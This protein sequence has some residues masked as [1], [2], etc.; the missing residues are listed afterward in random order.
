MPI[1]S[2]DQI[3]VFSGGQEPRIAVFNG[4]AILTA[5]ATD[6]AMAHIDGQTVPYG[7]KTPIVPPSIVTQATTD[8]A[9]AP[10]G[11][12]VHKSEWTGPADEFKGYACMIYPGYTPIWTYG[13]YFADIGLQVIE[14]RVTGYKNNATGEIVTTPVN[15]AVTASAGNPSG[16]F[17]FAIVPV[18]SFGVVRGNPSPLALAADGNQYATLDSQTAVITWNPSDVDP[19]ADK[20]AIICAEVQENVWHQV[21]LADRTAGTFTF[22]IDAE[23]LQAQADVFPDGY[24]TNS[25]FPPP[26]RAVTPWNNRLW[27]WCGG[28]DIMLDGTGKGKVQ[29]ANQEYWKAFPYTGKS[30]HG[31]ITLVPDGAYRFCGQEEGMLFYAINRNG[32]RISEAYTVDAVLSPTQLRLAQEWSAE[33]KAVELPLAKDSD[34]H[35]YNLT[36]R[37]AA[38]LPDGRYRF[39]LAGT[40]GADPYGIM[41]GEIIDIAGRSEPELQ[42][43][44]VIKADETFA[45]I[46]VD[47][48]GV[49]LNNNRLWAG[50]LKSVNNATTATLVEGGLGAGSVVGQKANFHGPNGL[51]AV[52]IITANTDNT[53]SW[54]GDLADW[55]LFTSVTIGTRPYTLYTT[56]LR[57]YPDHINVLGVTPAM[58]SGNT[59]TGARLF[60]KEK[61][62]AALC[63]RTIASA[64]YVGP[65]TTVAYAENNYR[66]AGLTW[67]TA[68]KTFDQFGISVKRLTATGIEYSAD[69][70]AW[71]A[72]DKEGWEGLQVV[73]RNPA[74][75][76]IRVETATGW[77]LAPEVCLTVP[78][79]ANVTLTEAQGYTECFIAGFVLSTGNVTDI[80]DWDNHPPCKVKVTVDGTVP[81]VINTGTRLLLYSSDTSI[82]NHYAT[83][84]YVSEHV[85]TINCD[86]TQKRT[87]YDKYAIIAAANFSGQCQEIPSTN[88]WVGPVCGANNSLTPKKAYFINRGGSRPDQATVRSITANT[89]ETITLDTAPPAVEDE[90][91]ALIDYASRAVLITEHTSSSATWNQGI[92][93]NNCLKGGSVWFLQTQEDSNNYLMAVPVKTTIIAS[94]QIDYTHKIYWD[95]DALQAAW[96]AF[97]QSKGRPLNQPMPEFD[98]IFYEWPE[99]EARAIV[100]VNNSQVALADT[101]TAL[102]ADGTLAGKTIRLFTSDGTPTNATIA[103]NTAKTV[104]LSAPVS[105]ASDQTRYSIDD[106]SLLIRLADDDAAWAGARIKRASGLGAPRKAIMSAPCELRSSQFDY[107]DT[108]DEAWPPLCSWTPPSMDG[109]HIE[110]AIQSGEVFAVF[111]KAAMILAVAQP[112]MGVPALSWHNYRGIGITGP[113]ALAKITDARGNLTPEDILFAARSG[114]M[115]FVAGNLENLTDNAGCRAL[116]QAFTD[117]SLGDAVGAYNPRLG[118]FTLSNLKLKGETDSEAGWRMHYNAT[119]NAFFLERYS[120]ATALAPIITDTGAMLFLEG[121]DRGHINLGHL[122]DHQSR[123]VSSEADRIA[124][125]TPATHWSG[126]ITWAPNWQG[127]ETMNFIPTGMLITNDQAARLVGAYVLLVHMTTGEIAATRIT[128]VTPPTSPGSTWLPTITVNRLAPVTSPEDI[129][130]RDHYTAGI[131]GAIHLQFVTG[132]LGADNECQKQL[133]GLDITLRGPAS[134][135]AMR[136]RIWPAGSLRDAGEVVSQT[137][138]C[139]MQLSKRVINQ[140]TI[141]LPGLVSQAYIAEFSGAVMDSNWRMTLLQLG[142]KILRGQYV[143]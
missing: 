107:N 91:I 52:K 106:R 90:R 55:Q 59:F 111:T 28:P 72:K 35:F 129:Q 133:T 109:Q 15:P 70:S 131:I 80:V 134:D 66:E 54:S 84:K 29:I 31:V 62:A 92:I 18:R 20:V 8:A 105:N 33:T 69:A 2:N 50:D 4:R 102:P 130:A 142:Y 58:L 48:P 30:Q 47:T 79:W 53:I 25:A 49:A 24:N 51:I 98:R 23:T 138:R 127:G 13:T 137:P 38:E 114:L 12:Y 43:M 112:G 37:E 136:L 67:Y 140:G 27:G 14:W 39:N 17:F 60:T 113:K 76:E 74:T 89:A 139:D 41:P 75:G 94:E 26:L 120:P 119:L 132:I 115:R 3:A 124:G 103:S 36:D 121:D 123:D 42:G 7:L 110:A 86:P 32:L 93:P 1:T 16:Q 143:Q 22:D 141:W 64:T 46:T 71:L 82:R 5:G 96:N 81:S 19:N 77:R 108:N 122:T 83:P 56:P 85:A 97:A 116:W 61:G 88:L 118:V 78:K 73:I 6:R 125:T 44:T 68:G 65:H 40:P 100:A 57:G 104:V 101:A 45:D 21:G 126:A 10:W 99:P 34:G 87:L 128:A 63:N 135:N 117:E 95:P 9:D 11:T